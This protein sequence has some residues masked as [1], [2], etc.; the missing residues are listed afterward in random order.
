MTELPDVTDPDIRAMVL[1]D[2]GSKLISVNC[3]AC[4]QDW[5]CPS[6]LV[7]REYEG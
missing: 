2:H 7:A 6:I 1:R 3:R 5:P 4:W